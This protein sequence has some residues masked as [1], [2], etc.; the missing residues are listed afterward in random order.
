MSPASCNSLLMR[1]LRMNE[2][3]PGREALL[4]SVELQARISMLLLGRL[5]Q[6]LASAR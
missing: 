4:I 5:T 1:E 6:V 2:A 3:C